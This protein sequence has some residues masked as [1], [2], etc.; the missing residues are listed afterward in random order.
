MIQLFPL[1]R[2]PLLQ[3]KSGLISEVASLESLISEVAS[4][5]GLISEVASL[6]GLI[7]EVASL[8]GR[9]FTS[10]LLYLHL[11]SDQLRGLS[12]DE[13][14]LIGEG[15]LYYLFIHQLIYIIER[16]EM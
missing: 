1:I 8:K 14:G 9:Q 6:E 4:L 11:E 15:L 2:P 5:E 3:Q 16:H 7:S 12:S 10:I 13:K